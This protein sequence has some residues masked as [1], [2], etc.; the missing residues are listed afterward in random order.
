M[1]VMRTLLVLVSVCQT[2]ALQSLVLRH[3]MS[4]A[5]PRLL[6]PRAQQG[7]LEDGF[8]GLM[9]LADN[10]EGNVE[11][12]L[13][14]RVQREVRELTGVELEDL[15]NPSK[16][17]NLER[18]KIVKEAELAGC[19]DAEVRAELETRLEKIEGDLYREKRTVFQGWLK[20]L[21]ISQ[22]LISLVLSGYM[23]RPP[24]LP[25]PPHP[26]APSPLHALAQSRRTPPRLRPVA[27]LR[28]LSDRH[29][30]HLAP[31]ARLLVLLALHHPL[32]ARAPPARPASKAEVPLLTAARA[33]THRLRCPPACQTF[34]REERPCRMNAEKGQRRRSGACP[35]V[36]DV[37]SFGPSRLGEARARLG[38]P[39]LTAADHRAAL[40]RQRPA[41]DLVRQPRAAHRLLRLL[42]RRG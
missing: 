41:A 35:S 37:A 38:I 3:H 42:L 18:E 19:T 11:P 8:K 33:S 6:S 40:R 39:W 34:A 16:V 23:A 15:L 7:P 10:S 12:E 28:R 29:H 1:V 2:A 14:E 31:C 32:A 17:V 9:P 25:V 27:G 36:A 4:P 26:L 24:C 30:R 21:F 22:S 13:V 20:G 5:R